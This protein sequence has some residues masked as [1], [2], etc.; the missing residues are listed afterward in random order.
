MIVTVTLN[1]ADDVT[2]PAR[3]AALPVSGD[4]ARWSG[5]GFAAGEL[6]CLGRG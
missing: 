4:D 5:L 6:L 2:F 3:V 1:P